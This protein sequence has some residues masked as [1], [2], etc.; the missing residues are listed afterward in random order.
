M[1]TVLLCAYKLKMRTVLN[2]IEIKM[3]QSLFFSFS[4]FLCYFQDDKL[5]YVNTLQPKYSTID[6]TEV[7]LPEMDTNHNG[8]D[9]D[10]EREDENSNMLLDVRIFQHIL[11]FCSSVISFLFFFWSFIFLLFRRVCQANKM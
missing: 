9:D 6:L 7:E 2:S 3:S 4:L 5:Q 11:C 8:N 1:F 10:V